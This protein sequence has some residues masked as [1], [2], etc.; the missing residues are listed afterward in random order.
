MSSILQVDL[1]RQGFMRQGQ[2]G[3]WKKHF[4]PQMRERF[5]RWEEEWLQ[6][7]DLKFTYEL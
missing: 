1:G 4:T 7:S 3:N 5:E 2:A 6:G